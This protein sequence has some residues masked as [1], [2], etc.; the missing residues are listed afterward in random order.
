MFAILEFILVNVLNRR[1]SRQADVGETALE[2][3]F[4]FDN[5]DTH[6]AV[7]IQDA[8]LQVEMAEPILVNELTHSFQRSL[9]SSLWNLLELLGRHRLK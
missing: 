6:D 1:R 7:I 2:Q 4:K 3:H 9:M 5:T 8:A